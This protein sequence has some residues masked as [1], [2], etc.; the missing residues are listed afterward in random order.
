[1]R[2]WTVRPGHEFTFRATTRAL[3]ATALWLLAGSIHPTPV[4]AQETHY[5]TFL[6]GERALGLGGAFTGISD[7]P[8]AAFYNP[9]GLALLR[10]A[11]AAGGLSVDA[12]DLY[13]VKDGYAT[14]LGSADLNHSDAPKVPIFG[15][16][17]TKFGKRQR[18]RS[19]NHA[20]ALSTFHP[21]Q[22]SL[23]F[24]PRL[25]G[26]DAD[27]RPI[28]DSLRITT[29]DS[30]TWWGPSYAYRL[31]RTLGIGI[32][33][34]LSTRQFTHTEDQT[35]FTAGLRDPMTGIYSNASVF[36][37]QARTSIK[38][39]HLV[40]RIGALWL[41]TKKLHLGLT[42][43][44]PGIPIT[45]QAKLSETRIFADSLGATPYTTYFSTT[46]HA[47][48][49]YPI[50]FEAHLGAAY[51]FSNDTLISA[52]LAF[53]APIGTTKSP[54][55]M[56]GTLRPDPIMGDTP[57]PGLFIAQQWTRNATVN[58]ALGFETVIADVV[59]ISFGAYTNF[60]AAPSIPA[61]TDMY[62]VDDVDMFGGSFAVGI[63]AGDYD[64]SV[65]VSGAYGVG[66]G[67]A[68][69]PSAGAG[70]RPEAYIRTEVEEGVVYFFLSGATRALGKLAQAAYNELAE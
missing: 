36:V 16:V 5:Q 42:F 40:F 34:F 41:P 48:T 6:V 32:S 13:K 44:I 24:S 1:M 28:S 51:D 27:L 50:P 35:S 67:L 55:R 70:P 10:A 65:G 9:G 68:L 25:R 22:H 14:G 30:M 2:G 23:S 58:A 17:V 60:S 31:T 12:W 39:R 59:P 46:Q 19:R 63:R 62:R 20:I 45:R 37:R 49:E 33:A 8:S 4:A 64:V 69:N 21:A 26:V 3:C 56:L 29:V 54:A 47:Y 43:Q 61:A 53:H 18:D 11:A 38:L 7:D 15:S 57:Q 66:D 52:D